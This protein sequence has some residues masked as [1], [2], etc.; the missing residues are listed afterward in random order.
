MRSARSL[1]TLALIVVVAILLHGIGLLQ[2]LERGVV[3]A[4]HPM[5]AAFSRWFPVFGGTVHQDQTARIAALEQDVVRLQV[6]QTQ[7][8]EALRLCQAANEQTATL[9]QRALQGISATVIGRSPEGDTQVLLIDRGTEKG[10]QN[11]QPVMTGTGVLIGTVVDA[12]VGRSSI[13][14]LNNTQSNVGAEV[15]NDAHSPGIVSG[16]RGLALRLRSIPQ[17]E[18]LKPGELVVTSALNEK[19]P[20]NLLIGDIT[21]VHFVTGDLFQEASIRPPLDYQRVRYVTVITS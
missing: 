7:S 16:E 3:E 15:R 20:A 5:Q 18:T 12:Q 21:E 4:M 10:V 8:D 14:L 6:E 9:G 19:V 1:L 2:P 13:L 11:E 17:N